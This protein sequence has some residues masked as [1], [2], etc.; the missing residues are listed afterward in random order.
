[1][2]I[3]KLKEFL[4]GHDIKYV[5]ISHLIALTAQGVTHISGKELAK[6]VIVNIDKA[7]ATVLVFASLH[8][9][10]SQLRSAASAENVAIASEEEFKERSLDCETGGMPPFGNLYDMPVFAGESL[11]RHKGDRVQ[12]RLSSRTRATRLGRFR[13]RLVEPKVVRFATGSIH[14][15]AAPSLARSGPHKPT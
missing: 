8:I 7:L 13:R 3:Q 4:D 12:C 5:V 11:A 6:T 14:S 10:L 1:M 9:D 2:P 15:T